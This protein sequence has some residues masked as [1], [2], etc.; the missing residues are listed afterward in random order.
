M[1]RTDHV[2][3]PVS[4]SHGLGSQRRQRAA[5]A[6]A[7]CVDGCRIDA[8]LDAVLESCSGSALADAHARVPP[9]PARPAQM[10]VGVCVCVCVCV[11]VCVCLCPCLCECLFL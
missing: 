6:E 1:V 11:F 3:S 4:V 8:E 10:C 9:S 2:A 5:G 7:F